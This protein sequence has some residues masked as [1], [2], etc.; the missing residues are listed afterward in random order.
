MNFFRLNAL[1]NSRWEIDAS[2]NTTCAAS[3]NKLGR[4]EVSEDQVIVDST[5]PLWATPTAPIVLASAAEDNRHL[6]DLPHTQMYARAGM[7]REGRN[8]QLGPQNRKPNSLHL[9]VPR[10]IL[11][12]FLY[13][14]PAGC[15]W[16]IKPK[17][18]PLVQVE[19]LE[20]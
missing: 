13:F 12:G 14:T 3:Q 10:K 19:R 6:V 1:Q 20:K 7:G 18:Q 17:T 9:S 11:A 4:L 16:H 2:D 5:M 8:E 15:H